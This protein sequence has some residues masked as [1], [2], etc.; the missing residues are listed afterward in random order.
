[1]NA[2][3]ADA[4]GGPSDPGGHLAGRRILV[5]GAGTDGEA[6]EVGIGRAI[7]LALHRRGATVACLDRVRARAEATE[8]LIRQEGGTS[9]TVVTDLTDPA[10][11]ERAASAAH[12][13]LGGL[14]GAVVNVGV[15]GASGFTDDVEELDLLWKVNLRAHYLLSARLLPRLDPGSSIVYVGSAVGLVAGSGVPGYEM[16]KAGLGALCRHV[17]WTGAERDIRANVVIAGMIDTPLRHRAARGAASDRGAARVPL[18]RLGTPA[19]VASAAAFLLSEDAS[20]VT[21]TS[22]VVDGG[23]TAIR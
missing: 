12:E 20:Y 15:V 18:G 19:E 2:D 6:D 16:T 13:Q 5:A 11:I 14:D 23:L 3:T 21:G 17:A 7:A 9:T 4:K 10:D 8:Q 1:M 22:L